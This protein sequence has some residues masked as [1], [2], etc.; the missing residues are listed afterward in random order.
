MTTTFDARDTTRVGGVGHSLATDAGQAGRDAVR[1]AVGDNPVQSGDLVLIF[2]NADYDLPALHEAARAAAGPAQ[3]VGATTCGAFTHEAWVQ[4]GCVAVHIAAHGMSFGVVHA[5]R[6]DADI[7]ASTRRAVETA[8][9]RAGTLLPHSVLL[10]LCDG[11]TPDQREMARGAYSVTSAMVPM[12]GGAAGD[13]LRWQ[14]TSTFGEGRELRNGIV[15]VWINSARP[16]A[17]SID[18]GWQPFGKPMLVTR[19]DG[20]VIHELDGQPALE[21]YIAARGVPLKDDARSFGEQC[22]ERP[23]GLPNAF[24]RYDLRQ[25]HERLA[26]GGIVLTTGVPEQ[27]VVRVMSSNA[28]ALLH[29]ARSAAEQAM[30]DLAAEPRMSLVFSCCTRAPLMGDRV[31][32]EVGLI[33]TTLGAVPAAGFLTCGE[34]A[35]VTGSTGIHN[36][37]VALLTL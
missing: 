2:P 26:D 35:R 31:R 21:A 27:T 16:L 4:R 24:G 10:L 28:E 36:S 9:D 20:A 33:S 5:E 25:V 13:D 17:V 30:D 8:R 37:S 14:A 7:A 3:V 1:M 19:A 15:A 6:D 23:I 32:D 18:H 12:V 29:G 11:L 34:F 22:M